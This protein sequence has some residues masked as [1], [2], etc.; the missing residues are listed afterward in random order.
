MTAAPEIARLFAQR[1][2]LGLAAPVSSS[3]PMHASGVPERF[4]DFLSWIGLAPSPTV[5]AICDAS[6][7]RAV[8]LGED[9][10]I[11]TFGCPANQLPKEQ[12]RTVVVRAGG[13]G[14]KT[15]R[16]LAPKAIH[17]AL[18]VPLPTLAP[19]E[20]ARAVFIA[21]DLD[22][23]GQALGYARGI[24]G[25]HAKLRSFVIEAG[26]KRGTDEPV[27]TAE[28][29]TIRRP[30][31]GKLVDIRIGAATRGGKAVRGK[32]LVFVGMDEACF[33]YADDGYSVT[34][35]QVYDAA[36]QRVVPGGQV[37]LVSTPWIEGYGVLEKRLAKDF[38]IHEKNLCAV[39]PTRQ[40]NPTWDP[41][42]EIERDM[43]ENDPENAAREIDAVPLPGGTKLF[44]SEEVL[45]I[46]I[47][48]DRTGN[49][50][51]NGA[52]HFGG[53]D[54]GYRKNS[55]ALA[56]SRVE[57]HKVVLAYMKEHRP[58]KGEPLRPSLVISEFADTCTK[59]SARTMAGDLHE[60]AGRD[61][62][63]R[64]VAAARAA[65]GRHD[66]PPEY[67]ELGQSQA[68][69]AARFTELRTMMS[70]GRAEIP[71]N[72][73]LLGQ[74]RLVVAKPT[75]G[76]GIQIV[77]PERAGAHGD[78]LQAVVN[79]MTQARADVGSFASRMQALLDSDEF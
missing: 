3:I 66:P 78:V 32:T 14:G 42:G 41:T 51:P 25:E 55:S 75:P 38:G 21:P 58:A 45:R 74:M 11:T 37:W 72:P 77:I 34:D 64:R 13:R 70:E 54:L 6:E 35:A 56:L 22:T 8:F 52:Q 68:D 24:L 19:G 63:L 59:Y 17:A 48:K 2:A 15:S 33:F 53:V 43:R 69:I 12:R 73:R 30:H 7:G 16:L 39:G 47:V 23:A 65:T 79:C 36:I 4:A 26:P 1:L 10:C 44:F 49:L 5:E 61:E 50:E 71:N 60:A 20:H 29:V 57:L 31:D 40:L 18:T 28:R 9:L 27:G 46:A 62:E 76:G 67:V